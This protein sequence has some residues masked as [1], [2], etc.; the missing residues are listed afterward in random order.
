MYGAS[1]DDWI[2]II[3]YL[4]TSNPVTVNVITIQYSLL[5]KESKG[6]HHYPPLSLSLFIYN[7]R[8]LSFSTYSSILKDEEPHVPPVMNDIPTE[9][10]RS[11]ILDPDSSKFVIMN[12]IVL[13][14]TLRQ[15]QTS[16][17]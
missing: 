10:G 5:K 2:G 1:S 9:Y 15:A 3:L 17:V 12:I 11:K 6:I 7:A 4:N 8:V 13:K 14:S 16:N